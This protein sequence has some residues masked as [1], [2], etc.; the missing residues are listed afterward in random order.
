MHYTLHHTTWAKHK[1]EL[2]RIRRAVFIEEQ[3]VPEEL[4]WDEHDETCHHILVRDDN[5]NPIATGR[6][7]PDGHIGRMAVLKSWREHGVGS[8]VL[9]ALLDYAAIHNIQTT[10]LHAQT[11][12][13]P[14]YEKHGFDVCSDEFMDAGIPHKTMQKNISP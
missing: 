13:I 6:I 14:F 11:T 7:K 3:H 8:A 1:T 10:Y 2:A 4:E 9:R 12:A 5:N